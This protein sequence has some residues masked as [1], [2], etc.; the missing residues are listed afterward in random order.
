MIVIAGLCQSISIAAWYGLS[1]L[2]QQREGIAGAVLDTL[3]YAIGGSQGPGHVFDLVERYDPSADEWTTITPLNHA[4]SF[5]AAA[6]AEGKIFVFGGRIDYNTQIE[7]VEMYDPAYDAWTDVAVL[8]VPR[9][10]LTAITYQGEIWVMGG[11]SSANGLCGRVDVFN[12]VTRTFSQPYNEFYPPRAGLAAAT[13]GEQ[14]HLLGG[15]YLSLLSNNTMWE[16][17]VWVDDTPMSSPRVNLGAAILGDSLIVFGGYNGDV[18]QNTAECFRFSTGEWTDF[19]S[20][21]FYREAPGVAVLGEEIYTF[22]G[23]GGYAYDYGYL[24]ST[25]KYV[26]PLTGIEDNITIQVTPTQFQLHCYPNPFNSCL[27]INL[28]IP[29]KITEPVEITFVNTLGQLVYRHNLGSVNPGSYYFTWKGVDR[30]GIQLPSGIYWIFVNGGDNG[31]S[32]PV[33]MIK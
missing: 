11:Y 29:S 9:E 22:G 19:D 24:A 23:Y 33:V 21:L 18:P 27:K 6:T 15:A 20:L 2:S 1:E 32:F 7:T 3:I 4:R 10:G 31:N 14:I 12:P 30:N 26:K 28:T 13:D 5:A 8:P 17:S 16:D 25:E